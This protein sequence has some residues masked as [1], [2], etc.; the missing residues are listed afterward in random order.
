MVG[1]PR[2]LR[3]RRRQDR[4]VRGDGAHVRR[5]RRS[6]ARSGDGARRRSARS[7]CSPAR[8]C[9]ASR[10]PRGSRVCSSPRRSSRSSSSSPRSRAGGHTSSSHIGSVF[11]HGGV[12]G[13]LQAAGLLFFAFAGYARIA[14]LGEEVRDPAQTIPRAIPL[15]LGDHRRPVSRRRCRRA[16]GGRPGGARLRATRPI[17]AAVRAAGAAWSVPVVRVGAAVA[18]LGS[19]LA[20]IAGI[21]RTTL[22]M[23]RNGRSAARARGGRRAPPGSGARRARGR[24]RRRAARRDDRSARCDRVLVVRRTAL[25][26]GRERVGVH[27]GRCAPAL[28]AGAQRRRPRR[29]R[30]A[31]RHAAGR[32]GRRR[33]GRAGRRRRDSEPFF[34]EEAAEPERNTTNSTIACSLAIVTPA[35]SWSVSALSPQTRGRAST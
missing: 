7:R 22:A 16:R 4:V 27:A 5:V 11:A 15:A 6:R 29:L 26:R 2:R 35:I 34:G 14:T 32:V 12:Y 21:G 13:V 10:A 33:C 9:A 28:A 17:A 8:T 1:L 25:L 31:R 20:L 3:V 18:S 19:L 23:A 24:G 30:D